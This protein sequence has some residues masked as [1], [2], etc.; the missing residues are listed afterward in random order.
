MLKSR[1]LDQFYTSK[2]ISAWCLDKIKSHVDVNT[3]DY[4][5]EP[6]AGTGAFFN[7]FDPKKRIG[8]DLDPQCDGVIKQDYLSFQNVIGAKYIVIG[9]PPF[10][11][12]SSLAVKFFN[13]SHFADYICFIVPKTFRKN[14][15]INRLNLH[16][17]LIEDYVVPEYS[18]VYNNKP[19]DVPCCFQ[20]WKRTPNK[21]KKI[22][23][24]KS[25]PDFTLVKTLDDA[26]LLIQRVGG[27]AGTI[28]TTN[29][30]KWSI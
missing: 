24:L 4:V 19:Y 14:S 13:H 29:L 28:K 27:G 5:L 26:D 8:I 1:D 30:N 10:G 7:L 9:N 2:K 22:K 12:N 17:T 25:H 6:S 21:R 15:V 18:F 20:I 11:K 3:F 23:I 16:F